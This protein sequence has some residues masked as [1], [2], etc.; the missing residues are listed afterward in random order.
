MEN[1]KIDDNNWIG[2][3]HQYG[4]LKVFSGI[5][6]D[7]ANIIRVTGKSMSVLLYRKLIEAVIIYNQEGHTVKLFLD[8]PWMVRDSLNRWMRIH[9]IVDTVIFSSAFASEN[10]EVSKKLYSIEFITEPK[11]GRCF[12]VPVYSKIIPGT[13]SDLLD[14]LR[15]FDVK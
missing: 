11:L 8:I 2:D 3:I 1:I 15:K 6:I 7:N 5:A 14:F 9:N 12:A 10:K 13:I 4:D